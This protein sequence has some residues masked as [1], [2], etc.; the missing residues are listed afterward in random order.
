MCLPDVPHGSLAFPSRFPDDDLRV[1]RDVAASPPVD[2]PRTTPEIAAYSYSV[3]VARITYSATKAQPSNSAA[4][5]SPV[6][7]HSA[8]AVSA[9]APM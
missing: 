1:Y 6:T 8:S 9:S 4:S 7:C 3:S 5:P 2:R